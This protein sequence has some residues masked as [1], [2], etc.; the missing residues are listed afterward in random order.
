[1]LADGSVRDLSAPVGPPLGIGWLGPR[2]DG[3]VE[4]PEGSTLLLFTDGLFERRGVPLDDGRAQVR[5]ILT[6][7]CRPAAGGRCATGCSRSCSG[8][9][10]RTTSRCSPSGRTRCTASGPPE[11]GPELLPPVLAQPV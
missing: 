7:V 11:A 5:E 4:M 6:G 8:R 3:V 9:A 10:S 2:V 1:M